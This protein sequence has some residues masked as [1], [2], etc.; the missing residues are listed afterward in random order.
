MDILDTKS[1][2]RIIILLLLLFV[3]IDSYANNNIDSVINVN[4][5][6]FIKNNSDKY[7]LI[8]INHYDTLYKQFTDTNNPFIIKVDFNGDNLIDFATIVRNKI[9]D[10]ID[11]LGFINNNNC[12]ECY[13]IDTFNNEG[14]LDIILSVENKGEWTSIDNIIYIDND[15]IT[16]ER[17]NES[18]SFS[19]YWKNSTF[20]KFYWD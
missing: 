7:E 12:F 8:T 10:K 2:N 17:F 6:K 16:V 20:M 11:L 13:F 14:K 4:L 15:G 1:R 19:Y 5:N 3:N 9:T 18:L